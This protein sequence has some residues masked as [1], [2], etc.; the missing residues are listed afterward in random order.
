MSCRYVSGGVKGVQRGEGERDASSSS[1]TFEA[2]TR[3]FTSDSRSRPPSRVSSSS[4]SVCPY[5]TADHRHPSSP[6]SSPAP[7]P[8]FDA[9]P[10]LAPFLSEQRPLYSLRQ[11]R[12][13]DPVLRHHH[14]PSWNQAEV[15]TVS[16]A[17]GER[18]GG[19]REEDDPTEKG[20]GLVIDVDS[21]E[22]LRTDR[23]RRD[24]GSAGK[25]EAK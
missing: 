20:A 13:V 11:R 8:L 6:F 23:G 22:A 18:G 16:R 7:L 1:A 14:D 12:L 19:V 9:S 3:L 10:L 24:W 15:R 17:L 4:I 21:V 25:S 2:R 5:A